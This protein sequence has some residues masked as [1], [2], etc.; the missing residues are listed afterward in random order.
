VTRSHTTPYALTPVAEEPASSTSPPNVGRL[1]DTFRAVGGPLVRFLW[2][3]CTRGSENVPE[4]GPAILAP[5][6]I[7][8]LDSPFLMLSLPRRITFVGK[9]EYMDD[10]KTKYLFPAVGM[11]PI[12]RKGGDASERA[13]AAAQG[14]LERGELFGIFPEGTRSRNGDLHRGHTGPARLALRTGAPIIPVGIRGTADI[15]PADA[16]LPRP[17]KAAEV[18]FG[19]PIDVTRYG[20]RQGDRMLLRQIID[21]VMFEIREMTGQHYVDEYAT[22]KSEGLPSEPQAKVVELDAVAAGGNGERRS[23]AEV[24]NRS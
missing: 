21:E 5:N 11:I 6:H 9:A 8:F 7:S 22:R 16:P 24:L 10:W 2:K 14:V 23:S 13:L 1:Y 20:D 15:Q 12:D 3:V 4:K 17:F 18:R 19:R